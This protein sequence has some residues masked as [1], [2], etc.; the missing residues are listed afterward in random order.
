MEQILATELLC[1]IFSFITIK[2]LCIYDTA[3][4][5]KD[6]RVIFL[7]ALKNYIPKNLEV[8]YWTYLKGI[9]ARNETCVYYNTK[10]ISDYCEKLV[11][12]NISS[13]KYCKYILNITNKNIVSLH[14]DLNKNNNDIILNSINAEKL[15][16]ITLVYIKFVNTD[17]FKLCPSL[18]K[19][20]FFK[21][22]IENIEEIVTENNKIDILIK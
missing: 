17:V 21:S 11:I 15:K 3:L 2:E 7:H 19:V 5:C 18:K 9:K 10:Y 14:I 22:D 4:T 20:V 6:N 13:N 8:C 1:I 12:N 16:V